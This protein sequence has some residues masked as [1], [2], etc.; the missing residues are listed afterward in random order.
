MTRS[1]NLVLQSI[2][3]TPLAALLAL[4]ASALILRRYRLAV[5]RLMNTPVPAA[6]PAWTPVRSPSGARP[7]PSPPLATAGPVAALVVA[8]RRRHVVVALGAGLVVGAAYA[9]LSLRWNGVDLTWHRLVVF[10]LAQAWPAVPAVWVATDGDRRATGVTAVVLLAAPVT[11]STLWGNGLPT[12][13]RWWVMTNLV[14]SAVVA[15]MLTRTFRAVGVCL[16]GVALVAVAGALTSAT[17]VVTFEPLGSAVAG[18]AVAVGVRDAVVVLLAVGVVGLV[19]AGGL[20]WLGFLALGR[21]YARQGFSDHMLLLGSICLVFCLDYAISIGAGAPGVVLLALSIFAALG[22][23]VVVAYRLLLPPVL[24]PRRLLVLRVFGEARRSAPLIVAVG[25]RWRFAGP[26]SMIGGPDLAA[27]NAE[28]DEVLTFLGRR[29]R[30]LFVA[31]G[32]DLAAR[33]ADLDRPPRPDP[34]GRYRVDEWFCGPQTW[35][36]AV[37][38]LLAAGDAVL[39][40]LRGFTAARR[41][42]LHELELLAGCGALSR[43]VLAVDA[44]TDVALVDSVVA[45]ARGARPAVVRLDG[46]ARQEAVRAVFM[47][48][49]GRTAVVPV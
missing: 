40:D 2:V 44:S 48:L 28:P 20:A 25:A 13:L 43:T 24:A 11:L 14:A 49:A 3:L 41:G 46:L 18:A 6:V 17:A 42:A 8:R 15:L 32:E 36:P 39:L 12:T 29:L 34:D 38:V 5:V 4:V 31:T 47:A 22:V 21:W 37:E 9:V 16:L 1:N 27:S 19:L 33:A 10:G 35:Q 7:A 23:L 26:V 45:G 30:R